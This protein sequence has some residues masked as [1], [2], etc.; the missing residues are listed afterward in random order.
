MPL[1]CSKE[2]CSYSG[3]YSALWMCENCGKIFCEGHW[4]E[5]P[6][7]ETEKDSCVEV[8]NLCPNCGS[9]K[10]ASEALPPNETCLAVD[11]PNVEDNFKNCPYKP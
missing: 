6:T 7:V 1:G 11:C 2:N 8:V 4:E 9:S 10:G 3:S 5:Q